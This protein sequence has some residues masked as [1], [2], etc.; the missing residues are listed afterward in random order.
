MAPRN[1]EAFK[2][3]TELAVDS[4]RG[5][6]NVRSLER[7]VDKLGRRF[8]RLGPEIDK[9]LKGKELGARFGQ[10]FSSSATSL[11]TG[12]FDALGQTLGS[13]IGTAIAPGIGTAIGS[14]VGSGV[15]AALSKISGPIQQ[16]IAAGIELNKQLELT[17][18]E[19][20]TFAG[21]EKE[22]NRYLADLKKLSIDTGNKFGWVIDTSEH[23]FD[24]TSNLK[25]TDTILRAAVDHAA[26]FGG[27]AETI[28]KVGEA[29][30]LIAEKG[31]IASREL[32]KLYKLG[33]DAK[34][35]LSQATGLTEKQIEKLMAEDRLR[36]D[37][38]ARLIAEGISR[39]KAGFAAK[40]TETTVAGAE[41]KF[42]VLTEIRAAEG[43]EKA[44]Q[45]Y[46]DFLRSANQVLAGEK[47]KQFVQYIDQAT[48]SLIN[49][50]QTGLSTG[51]NITKGLADGIAS[52]DGFK[53]VGA[54]VSGLG[55]FTER[56]LK[57]FWEI[58]SPSKRAARVGQWIA[59]GIALGMSKG[60]ASNYANLKAL[61]EADP[62]FVR[63]LAAGAMKRGVNPDDMLNLI[64]IESSFNKSVM[65]KWGY[66][67]LGQVGRDERRSLGLPVNDLA[68]KDLLASRSASWQMENVLFPFLDMKLKANPGVE[69]GGVSLAELYAMWGSGHAKGDP[70]FIHMAKGGKRAKAYANNPLWDFDKDG[71]V[72]ESEFGQSAFAALGAGRYFSVNGQ[73]GVSKGNPMPVAVVNWN[74]PDIDN[75]RKMIDW[76]AS[77]AQTPQTLVPDMTGYVMQLGEEDAAIVDVIASKE[78]LI[79]VDRR[80][81]AQMRQLVNTSSLVPRALT[82][83]IGAEQQ[84]AESAI[85][86]TDEYMEAARKQLVIGRSFL[87]QLSSAIGQ[88][89]GFMPQ[90]QVGKKRGFWS[91]ALGIAAP[92]LSFIP[93]VG[94]LLSTLAGTA[95]AGLSGD[96]AG[97]VTGVAGGLQ[98]GGAFR[99]SGSPS[100]STTTAAGKG[101]GIAGTRAT[102]GRGYRGRV[103]W[104]GERG[105]EPF[106]ARE[107]GYFLSHN[108]AMNAMSSGGES[109]G[110]VIS[111]IER[112]TAALAR[113]EAMPPDHVV[114]LGARGL[115]DAYDQDAGLIRLTGQRFRLA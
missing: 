112:L 59:E 17:T 42:D 89:S 91:K 76:N 108:D 30:G 110:A 55:D 22:A 97:V 87:T 53:A 109:S 16:R 71:V 100:G 83:L 107:D 51:I 78:E 74:V 64:G 95:A 82:P 90:Q 103:Y 9:A 23:I 26:D 81:D 84:H 96:W 115:V 98:P 1:I 36:G 4:A 28:R 113:L 77:Q 46:G 102:G 19:F 45:G 62:D 2:L 33:I 72:R 63:T 35:Y 79:R 68:F 70:N 48:G 27:E 47:A 20:T 99:R 8:Q 85:K 101:E 60:Q 114:R 13:V 5:S 10:S 43:T 80:T 40:L 21:S 6:Q 31:N 11:I 3:R 61:S 75:A 29:L 18:R 50:V 56:Q 41:R 32:Q 104:A 37:V 15:D 38:A 49:L 92:F 106:L 88:I 69:S 67:G 86:L 24:L 57:S 34:K 58:D 52:T 73:S 94:P 93:G 7:D 44:T 65:N 66:G 111:A 12:S 14:T 105:P 25:L 54:A 39:E